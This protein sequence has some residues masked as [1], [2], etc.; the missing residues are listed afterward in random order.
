M[1]IDSPPSNYLDP[2]AHDG[3]Q[4]L[5]LPPLSASFPLPFRVL[6]LIGF[7]ILLWGTNLHILH[8]LGI[9]AGWILDFRDGPDELGLPK[10]NPHTSNHS[11]N[12]GVGL[13]VNGSA[14]EMELEEYIDTPVKIKAKAG[15]LAGTSLGLGTSA[16]TSGAGAASH[17]EAGQ[18]L[19]RELESDTPTRA[20]SPNRALPAP[21]VDS[22][23]LHQPIYKLFL[24]YSIWVGA[25]WLLFRLVTG[26]EVESMERWRGLIALV[27]VGAGAGVVL[28]WRGVGERERRALNR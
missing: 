20:I 15:G 28:P 24:L 21:R 10:T 11:G 22:A 5:L 7:A 13:G 2:H 25:G 16:A 18:E 14:E 19:E 26:G 4:H 23:K 27:V 1:D 12:L 3:H 8:L 6:V 17:S 9:D